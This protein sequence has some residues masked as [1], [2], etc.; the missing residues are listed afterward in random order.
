MSDQNQTCDIG[1]LSA[2]NARMVQ[3]ALGLVSHG[4][5]YD[6]GVDLGNETPRLPNDIVFGFTLTQ[7]RRPASFAADPELLGNSFSLEVIHGSLHQSSHIDSLIHSQRN[8]RIYGGYKVDD[9]LGDFGWS[10]F[11]TETIPPI[12]SRGVV[13]DAAAVVGDVPISDGY[14][15]TAEQLQEA[16]EAQGVA[17]QPGDSVLIRTGK[18]IQYSTDRPAFEAGCPESR[19]MRLAGWS[20]RA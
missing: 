2:M 16:V 6:L 18:I 4:R 11:G 20:N 14:G 7:F 8:G 12:I 9:L 17:L 10:A 1:A 5:V 3:T 13:I 19:V 15:A